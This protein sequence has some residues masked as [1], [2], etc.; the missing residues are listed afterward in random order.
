MEISY[1]VPVRD[2]GY[3]RLTRVHTSS[4]LDARTALLCLQRSGVEM[5]WTQRMGTL[6][7]FAREVQ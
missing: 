2:T 4:L 3:C 7:S 5:N 6:S 1:W